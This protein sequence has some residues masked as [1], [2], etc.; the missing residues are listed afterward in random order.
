VGWFSSKKK[1]YVDTNVVRLVED[2][3]V[4]SSLTT[5][6]MTSAFHKKDLIPTIRDELMYGSGRNFGRMYRFAERGDYHYGLPDAQVVGSADGNALAQAAIES[7]VGGT[8]AIE[9]M[10][11]RPLNNTHAAWKVIYEAGEYT[12]ATNEL[13][14]LTALKGFTCYLEKIVAVHGY[15]VGQEPEQSSIGVFGRSSGSGVTPGR[16]VWGTP[17]AYENLV[18]RQE[19]IYTLNGSEGAE[20]HA[21]WLDANGDEQRDSY[22]IDLSAYDEDKEYYQAR[23]TYLGAVGYWTYDVDTGSHATLDG[24]F[25]GDFT[26]SGSYFPFAV[27]RSEGVNRATTALEAT[28][29]YITT[30]KLLK[31]IGMDFREMADA[32]HDD[33][34]IADVTQA[35]LM[36]AVP[37]NSQNAVDM[38]YLFRYF[39]DLHDNVVPSDAKTRVKYGGSLGLGGQ[40]GPSEGTEATYSVVISDAD[41]KL[42]MSFDAIEQRL[43][44]GSIGAVG[45]LTNTDSS[46]DPLGTTFA[47]GV[48]SSV[49]GQTVRYIRKQINEHIYSEVKVINARLR[50]HITDTL[51]AEGSAE[52]GD[53]LIPLDY[54]IVRQMPV[55]DEQELYFRSLHFVFNS[56]VVQRVKWYQSGLFAAI[57]T[58]IAIV[59][60]VLTLGATWQAAVIAAGAGAGTLA[61]VIV[62][63][64]LILIEL[65]TAAASAYAFKEIAEAV[66]PEA[67]FWIAIAAAIYGGYK[68]F[69]TGSIAPGTTAHNL[70]AASNGLLTGAQAAL[71]DLFDEYQDDVQEFK[72]ITEGLQEELDAANDLL[73]N[74]PHVNPFALIGPQPLIL[75]GEPV[76]TYYERMSHTGNVGTQSLNLVQNFLDTSLRLP[77]MQDTIGD[78]LYG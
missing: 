50:Y 2:D 76:E 75:F 53:L 26:A 33:A 14:A 64:K 60:T 16:P 47:A 77:S 32:M 25:E 52:D 49:S 38:D 44:S 65:V 21:V 78:T 6:L 70:L 59:V 15:V 10:H 45:T 63:I 40:F 41:F 3:Q 56:H 74:N 13:T 51:G 23:Y 69:K 19:T 66:G 42:S 28:Q 8:V 68:G 58:I 48:P 37:I 30:T 43:K 7:E 71:S 34:N 55:L 12:E 17:S 1:H 36:M 29:E 11:F 31:H 72:L 9:Y 57:I 61:I 73:N 54:D 62:F 22:L 18:V 5:A 24:V 35:V 20:I 46:L 4:P 67:A 39:E 27:F